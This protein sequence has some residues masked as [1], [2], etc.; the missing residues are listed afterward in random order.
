MVPGLNPGTGERGVVDQPG[1]GETG[2]DG[3]GG[4]V[5]DAAAV[6]RLG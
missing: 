1:I 6:H 2:Q 4:F 3:L 5:R